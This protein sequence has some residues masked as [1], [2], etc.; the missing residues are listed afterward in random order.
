MISGEACETDAIPNIRHRSN[1]IGLFK[2][3]IINLCNNILS[4]LDWHGR[5]KP[6]YPSS[7]LMK[8]DSPLDN[9]DGKH[10]T[11]NMYQCDG[12]V[13]ITVSKLDSNHRYVHNRYVIHNEDK[14]GDHIDR[15][16]SFEMIRG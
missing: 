8:A 10:L 15:I 4:S 5:T 2:T 7:P 14:L 13:L 16:V 12:G 3:L 11:F 1:K 6:Q 9:D